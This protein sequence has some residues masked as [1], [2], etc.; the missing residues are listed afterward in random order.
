MQFSFTDEDKPS[1]V[2][3]ISRMSS[4]QLSPRKYAMKPVEE[5]RHD[6]SPADFFGLTPVHVGKESK[7]LHSTISVCRC[8]WNM[9]SLVGAICVHEGYLLYF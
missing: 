2:D 3:A 4:K 5:V 1:I 8:Y 6:I 9:L 7:V